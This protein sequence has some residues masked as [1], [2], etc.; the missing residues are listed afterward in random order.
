M[1]VGRSIVLLIARGI[2][3]ACT[4]ITAVIL[5]SLQSWQGVL[6]ILASVEW[7]ELS[8]VVLVTWLVIRNGW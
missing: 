2:V 3:R 5:P 7:G 8:M 6:V 4:A 1:I